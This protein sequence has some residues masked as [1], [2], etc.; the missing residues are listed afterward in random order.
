MSMDRLELC[1][2]VR[3]D[4]R[5]VNTLNRYNNSQTQEQ[6]LSAFSGQAIKVSRCNEDGSCYIPHPC[7]N[8]IGT[9]QT[10]RIPELEKLGLRTSGFLD[11][12]LFVCNKP[13]RGDTLVG[14]E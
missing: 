14:V 3:M 9:T 2:K 5:K 4:L 10:H 11:R 12:I 8:L 1:N 7:V 13:K 6:L